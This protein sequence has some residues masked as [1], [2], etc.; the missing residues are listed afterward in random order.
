[1]KGKLTKL[2]IGF[3]KRVY[4]CDDIYKKDGV[5]HLVWNM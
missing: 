1:M 3:W 2:Y 5:W 4:K